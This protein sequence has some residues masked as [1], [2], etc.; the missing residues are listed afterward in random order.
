MVA[1]ASLLPWLFHLVSSCFI[2]FHL[3]RDDR[4]V[5]D[6]DDGRCYEPVIAEFCDEGDMDATREVWYSTGE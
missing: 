3:D 2:L 6:V 4:D 1:V 5:D